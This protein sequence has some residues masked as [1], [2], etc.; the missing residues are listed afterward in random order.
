MTQNVSDLMRMLRQR[1]QPAVNAPEQQIAEPPATVLVSDGELVEPEPQLPLIAP[2]VAVADPTQS[3][4]RQVPS[5]DGSFPPMPGFRLAS[6]P[7]DL[8][9]IDPHQPRRTLPDDLRDACVQGL[10]GTRKAILELCRRAQNDDRLAAL[11]VGQLRELANSIREV[12]LEY[13]LKVAKF[14]VKDGTVRY[15]IVEGERRFWAWLL[16]LASADET[17][18][19]YRES[20]PAMVEDDDVTPEHILKAQWAANLQREGVPVVDIADYVLSVRDTY[21]SRLQVD[22]QKWV[23]SLGE[24]GRQMSI[25]EA[26]AELT[27]R[28]VAAVMGKRLS[29]S[30]LFRYLAIA[31]KLRTD[32]KAIA[33]VRQF[34]LRQC[35]W[36][37]RLSP[38]QQIEAAARM[39][40]NDEDGDESHGEEQGRARNTGAGRPKLL[41]GRITMLVRVAG[42]V[43][44]DKE[45]SLRKADPVKLQELRQATTDAIGAL[46]GYMRLIDRSLADSAPIASSGQSSAPSR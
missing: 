23:A 19:A 9:H 43:G 28:E 29:R 16:L 41:D 35:E 21:A 31:E 4:D 42:D 44:R 3:R 26:V 39:K 25:P 17:E 27:M 36:L 7:V 18:R 13:P 38:I 32:V 11:R 6:I 12:G 14:Q 34:G 30:N 5:E 15:R 45:T 24:D 22:P 37:A 33:R 1:S 40:P 20:I 2:D 46:Q 8:I 10:L